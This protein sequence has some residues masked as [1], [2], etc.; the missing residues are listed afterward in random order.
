MTWAAGDGNKYRANG[1][2]GLA[3][4]RGLVPGLT[5]DTKFGAS[6]ISTSK[7]TIWPNASLYSYQS[8]AVTLKLS[9][10]STDDDL[11]G[12]GMEKIR[13]WG[14]DTNWA[15]ITEEVTLDGQNQVDTVNQYLRIYRASGTQ[16]GGGGTNAGIIYAGTG[17]AIA[18]VPQTTIDMVITAGEGQTLMALRP[19]PAGKRMFIETIDL[20]VG[21]GKTLVAQFVQRDFGSGFNV[22]WTETI[23]QQ[24]I[25]RQVWLGP[26]EEKSDVE[27]RGTSGAAGT[28]VSA[29]FRYHLI[30][31]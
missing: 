20:S 25:Q 4:Q 23:F 26:Y 7:V 29:G 6:T 5:P 27:F 22:K 30:E 10:G 24:A 19:V 17:T 18:G 11:G 12:T 15:E 2:F 16:Y 1:P 13:I 3:A 31:Y 9:S 21:E 28:F 14:L 8:S